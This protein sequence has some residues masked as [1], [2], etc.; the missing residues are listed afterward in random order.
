MDSQNNSFSSSP[1][2]IDPKEARLRFLASMGLGEEVVAKAVADTGCVVDELPLAEEE[3]ALRAEPDDLELPGAV[4]KSPVRSLDCSEEAVSSPE[5]EASDAVEENE[6]AVEDK[7]MDR[8][9]T[10]SNE[11]LQLSC[12]KCQGDLVLMREHLGIEGAC[13]WC[14]TKIVAARS[15]MDGVV[16]VFPLFQPDLSPSDAPGKEAV[17][18]TSEEVVDRAEE[19]VGAPSAAPEKEISVEKE[20]SPEAVAPAAETEDAFQAVVPDSWSGSF[21]PMPKLEEP[22]APVTE[23]EAEPSPDL[24]AD[25]FG[26]F[27]GFS[28]KP[29]DLEA[30]D[31]TPEPEIAEADRMPSGFADGFRSEPFSNA[32]LPAGEKEEPVVDQGEPV[33][34]TCFPDGFSEA[35]AA[36]VADSGF[37]ESPYTADMPEAFTAAVS[38]EKT[39]G[40]EAA[41]EQAAGFPGAEIWGAPATTEATESEASTEE[42]GDAVSAGLNAPASIPDGFDMAEAPAPEAKPEAASLWDGPDEESTPAAWGVNTEAASEDSLSPA[43][44]PTGKPGPTIDST[45]SNFSSGFA[46]PPSDNGAF[47]MDVPAASQTP[48]TSIPEKTE[49]LFDE[50]DE[51][52]WGEKPL[53]GSANEGEPDTPASAEENRSSEAASFPPATEGSSDA[54]FGADSD[55]ESDLLLETP[56]PTPEKMK[57]GSPVFAEEAVPAGAP[58]VTSEPLGAGSKKKRGKGMIVFLVVILGLVCGAALASFVLPV[59]EYVATARSFMEEK[60]SKEPGVDPAAFISDLVSPASNEAVNTIIPVE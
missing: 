52:S 45:S 25:S 36:G 42:E 60:L 14:E 40:D 49:S 7:A 57:A 22:E 50:G 9:D 2:G 35:P 15:G 38:E 3:V 26:A 24:A 55:D 21:D 11:P 12:P 37:S 43:D 53:F 13:V 41:D 48:E 31:S 27:S 16:R 47:S 6:P 46:I 17:A 29:L 51:V 59:D 23:V 10:E 34:A 28:D 56:P 33:A 18:V 32:A 44:V 1:S 54:F 39:G 5:V 58:K 20:S 19:K 4:S 30:G 8:P